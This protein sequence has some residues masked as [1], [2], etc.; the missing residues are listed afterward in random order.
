MIVNNLVSQEEEQTNVYMYYIYV[1]RKVNKKVLI[2]TNLYNI[3]IKQCTLIG[4]RSDKCR[5]RESDKTRDQNEENS[6]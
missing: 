5:R 3:F 6:S 4:R 2:K 1:F